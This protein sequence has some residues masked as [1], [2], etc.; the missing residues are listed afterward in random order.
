[1]NAKVKYDVERYL[2]LLIS[3]VDTLLGVFGYNSDKIREQVI[4]HAKQVML[5]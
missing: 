1:M 4:Y 3:A 5:S 2:E